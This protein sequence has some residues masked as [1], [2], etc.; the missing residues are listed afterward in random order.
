MESLTSIYQA[1]REGSGIG[2]SLQPWYQTGKV[3]LSVRSPKSLFIRLAGKGWV[4]PNSI[5]QAGKEKL[6][7]GGGP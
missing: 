3:E 1:G 5:H 2:R 6:V 4:S 7:V